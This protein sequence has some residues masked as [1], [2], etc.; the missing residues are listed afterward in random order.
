MNHHIYQIKLSGFTNKAGYCQKKNLNYQVY[1]VDIKYNFDNLI[2]L[3][4]TT[5]VLFLNFSS[6]Y[7]LLIADS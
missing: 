5:K 4:F 2:E 7:P 3:K 6:N 1:F